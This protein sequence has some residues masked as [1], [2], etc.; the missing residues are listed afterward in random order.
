MRRPA[1]SPPAGR[2]SPA[3]SLRIWTIPPLLAE[4]YELGRGASSGWPDVAFCGFPIGNIQSPLWYGLLGAWSRAGAPLVPLYSSLLWVGF[5]LPS[6]A[7]YWVARRRI[8]PF[9]AALLSYALLIQ[10]PSIVGNA[11]AFGGMWSTS[12]CRNG[13]GLERQYPYTCR[14]SRRPLRSLPRPPW[15]E[16]SCWLRFTQLANVISRN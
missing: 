11:S 14:G 8:G 13:R 4:A 2:S 9:P 5:V 15:W 1:A 6:L 12:F 3:A 16:T 7:L 10:R